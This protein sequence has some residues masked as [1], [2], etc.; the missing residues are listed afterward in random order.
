M[1]QMYFLFLALCILSSAKAS[2]DWGRLSTIS[3]ND[4]ITTDELRELLKDYATQSK[5]ISD[6]SNI[7]SVL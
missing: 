5:N 1:F 6:V 3:S 2:T 7:F 4:K